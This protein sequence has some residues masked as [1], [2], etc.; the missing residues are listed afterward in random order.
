VST[1]F[2]A[3]AST[4]NLKAAT[5]TIKANGFLTGDTLSI[6]DGDHVA[7]IVVSANNAIGSISFAGVATVAEYQS[8]IRSILFKPS[9]TYDFRDLNPVHMKNIT[10]TLTDTNDDESIVAWR[11]IRVSTAL[12]VY[13]QAISTVITD[14]TNGI[15]TV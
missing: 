6:V 11:L 1:L 2:T 7:S 13:T 4:P 15:I 5:L 14:T 10:C 3:A 8:A 9:S 12:R